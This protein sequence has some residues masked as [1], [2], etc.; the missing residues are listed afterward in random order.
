MVT[1]IR[2][3][4]VLFEDNKSIYVTE[5]AGLSTDQKPTDCGNGSTFVAMDTKKLYA[6]NAAS[7][8]WIEQ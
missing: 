5:Y 3:G 1:I 7:S 8:T 2:T 6:F 4:N